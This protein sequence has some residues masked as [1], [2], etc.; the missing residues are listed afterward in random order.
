MNLFLKNSQKFSQRNCSFLK[1]L[2]SEWGII[3]GCM[4]KLCIQRGG[5]AFR[6]F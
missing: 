1:G 4:H 3:S 5:Q 2:F 6:G